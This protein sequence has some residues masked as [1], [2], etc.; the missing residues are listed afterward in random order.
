MGFSITDL[1]PRETLPENLSA[2]M[3][4]CQSRVPGPPSRSWKKPS[5][6]W[7]RNVV[8]IFII[9]IRHFGLCEQ[10]LIYASGNSKQMYMTKLWPIWSQLVIIILCLCW[11]SGDFLI[12][13]WYISWSSRTEHGSWISKH[14]RLKPVKLPNWL[15]TQLTSL[16]PAACKARPS[17]E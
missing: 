17:E 16:F 7:N 8:S 4:P 15:I 5:R 10:M 2:S 9:V 14:T 13:S 12:E 6:S 1:A 3:E 11:L